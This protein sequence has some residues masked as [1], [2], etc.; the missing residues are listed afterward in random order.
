MAGAGSLSLVLCAPGGGVW[1]LPVFPEKM[2]Y[3]RADPD[4]RVKQLIPL[5][6]YNLVSFPFQSNEKEKHESSNFLPFL[7]FYLR[8]SG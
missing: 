4:Y 3:R 7:F 5:S 6:V 8:E 2:A 1:F